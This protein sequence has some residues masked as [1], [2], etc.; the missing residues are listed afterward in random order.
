MTKRFAKLLPSKFLAQ[1]ASKPSGLFGRYIVGP[2]L[3]RANR[4]INKLV[5]HSLSLKNTDHVLEIG[6]GPGHLIK[7]IAEETVEGKVIG[8]DYSPTM[9]NQACSVNAKGLMSG[10]VELHIG[11]CL[12]MPFADATFDKVCCVNVI[13]FWSSP[14]DNL[15][16]IYRV[17]K[18][19]GRFVLGFRSAK[20]L[21]QLNLSSDIFTLYSPKEIQHILLEAGF[22]NAGIEKKNGVPFDAYCAIATKST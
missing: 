17:M 13:Y 20:Q 8:L 15:R 9:Y 4:A 22:N 16:E 1:Q 10:H 3:I 19:G 12:T 21:S 11:D 2:M 14:V 18:P 6:Y 7:Q 5:Q